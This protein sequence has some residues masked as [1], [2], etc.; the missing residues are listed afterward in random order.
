MVRAGAV[1]SAMTKLHEIEPG[2][3]SLT[4][5]GADDTTV[6]TMAEGG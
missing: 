1:V 3:V 5:H 4:I 2:H 6:L